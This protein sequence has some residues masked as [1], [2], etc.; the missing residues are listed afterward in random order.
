MAH[1]IELRARAGEHYAYSGRSVL[2]TD[3]AGNVTGSGTEGFY[4][5]N[6]RLLC[7]EEVTIDGKSLRPVAVSPV[8]GAGFFA[9]AEA[10]PGPTIPKESVYVEIARIVAEGMRTVLRVENYSLHETARFE[11]AMHL[12]ADFADTE[13]TE[14]GER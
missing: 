13:E 14:Q 11:L 3:L 5:E 6:T 7:R 1:R 9:Y 8:G 2:V 4:V 12:A 10:L